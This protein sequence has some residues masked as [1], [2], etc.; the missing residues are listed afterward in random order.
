[1]PDTDL[2]ELTDF[3][4]AHVQ[5]EAASQRARDLVG[6]LRREV[7]KSEFR[8]SHG[9]RENWSLNR[10]LARVSADFEEREVALK[11]ARDA[12]EAAAKAKSEFLANMSHE[13]RTPMNGVIGMT[14]LLLD[15]PLDRDQRDFVETIRMSGEALLTIINDILDFS[16]IEAGRLD[17]EEAPFDICD[18]VEGSLDLVAQTAAQKGVELA[19]VVEEGTPGQ[20]VGDVTRVR[21][22]LVNLLSNAVKFTTS[23]SVYVRI[24]V[25]PSPTGDA[26]SLV[27][28]V[29]DTGIGIAPDKVGAVFESFSQADAS[30]TRRFG[31]TGL[32]LTICRRLVEMMGGEIGVESVLGEGSVFTFS[33]A[34]RVDDRKPA[35][36]MVRKPAALVGRRLL[37]VD[38]NP[39]NREILA[40]RADRWGM[41]MTEAA[42]GADALAQASL[43]ET[44]GAPF[45]VVLLDMQMPGMDGLETARGLRSTLR[46][47]P[48]MVMLT[49]TPRD[50]A[51]QAQA[52]ESGVDAFLYKPIKPA[53]L[54]E[55]LVGAFS[56]R[57]GPSPE[58]PRPRDHVPAGAAGRAPSRLRVL[59]A[60]DNVV[61]QKVAVRTLQR[62]G[63]DADVA[64]DGAETLDALR[65]QRYDVVLM[66]V[67][68]P[69]VDGLEATRR[70]HAEW[71][72]AERPVVIALTAN[73]MDGD[74]ERCLEAGCDGY[75]SKPLDRAALDD[76]LGRVRRGSEHAPAAFLQP[77]PADGHA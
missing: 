8:A 1:M 15:T 63:Y 21:Q 61:N 2:Q 47:P 48:V 46:K 26:L 5:D 4:S 53:Q 27:V 33:V 65:R 67:Q 36:F 19:Y 50:A 13:I 74:R 39:V 76:A 75:L 30:T 66:D 38:D 73:A 58:A 69:E 40:Y 55:A 37:I 28:A 54:H 77:E 52:V 22:V 29:K 57:G 18:C 68:M 6:N 11:D 17:L 44:E 7:A 60:E 45:E 9:E 14:S 20:V 32:G 35:P 49:S 62:L 64:A 3:L 10:L 41:P 72:R 56:E 59:L 25:V 23:G 43:A 71:S 34:V 70:I 12:A 16:K 31:G 42:S 24:S 51:L